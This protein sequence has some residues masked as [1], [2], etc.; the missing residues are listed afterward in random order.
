MT[1]DELI[2]ALQKCPDNVEVLIDNEYGIPDVVQ[3]IG[4]ADTMVIFDAGLTGKIVINLI[5]EGYVEGTR[6]D[7]Q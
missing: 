4:V 3:S 2:A 1:R 7:S 6:S 5:G